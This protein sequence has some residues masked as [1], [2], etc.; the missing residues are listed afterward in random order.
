MAERLS[1]EGEGETAGTGLR[2]RGAGH[3]WQGRRW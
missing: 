2:G 1:R 3:G